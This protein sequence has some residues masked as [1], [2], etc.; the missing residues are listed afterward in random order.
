MR[1][2]EKDNQNRK[3]P[4]LVQQTLDKR[5][6]IKS[7]AAAAVSSGTD[8]L[9]T[10]PHVRRP[11]R[12]IARSPIEDDI[13]LLD[14]TM[15]PH[16]TGRGRGLDNN[17]EETEDNDRDDDA[18]YGHDGSTIVITQHSAA[19]GSQVAGDDCSNNANH[20]GEATNGDTSPQLHVSQSPVFHGMQLNVS[21]DVHVDALTAESDRDARTDNTQEREKDEEK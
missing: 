4:T 8:D 5:L 14:S 12:A 6:T 11:R 3:K 20:E 16:D 7:A 2:T 1:N 19:P 9:V 13:E 18:M 21:A 10:L 17:M 15:V